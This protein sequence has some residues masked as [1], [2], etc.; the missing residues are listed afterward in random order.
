M[1]YCPDIIDNVRRRSGWNDGI[2]WNFNP[3]WGCNN[4]C[5]WGYVLPILEPFNVGWTMLNR[6]PGGVTQVG[7][8]GEMYDHRPF[9]KLT[10]GPA[11]NYYGD[12]YD[13]DPLRSMPLLADFVYQTD[14]GSAVYQAV[15]HS[16]QRGKYYGPFVDPIGGNS[17]WLDG[18]CEW[19]S[20][21][22]GSRMAAHSRNSYETRR[23]HSP[24]LDSWGRLQTIYSWY[25][26]VKDVPW[27]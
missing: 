9:V 19:H 16:S 12:R 25:T 4:F 5:A 22:P 24:A 10:D 11:V 6:T 18:H 27:K 23:S 15:A 20:W 7:L 3:R 17:M 26:W 8:W 2:N 1:R 21:S 14:G 13:Y